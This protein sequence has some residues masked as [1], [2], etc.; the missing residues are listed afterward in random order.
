MNPYSFTSTAPYPHKVIRH[1]ETPINTSPTPWLTSLHATQRRG[2]YGN[3]SY[4]GN[5]SGYLIK[6][7]IRYFGARRIL[8]PL[9]GSGTCR[10][11]CDEL[12]VECVSFDLKEGKD[13]CSRDSYADLG[14]FDFIWTHPP[15]WRMINY[16]DDPR[17]MSNAPTLNTFIKQMGDLIDCCAS[18]L[19]PNGKIAVLM[20][21]YSEHGRYLPLTYLTMQE[22]MRRGLWPACTE[23]VRLQYRN[24]S[25]K[26]TY[27]S[28]FIPGVHDTCMVFE[29]QTENT[30][31]L[32]TGESPRNR[33]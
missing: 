26:K 18:V 2:P 6:D 13:A 32:K 22:A 10:D 4:R 11:V 19:S 1:P 21:N 28:S 12:N 14:Q 27:S 31:T 20:G 15:Y 3:A 5:C 30:E 29:V 16:G 25:S 8:D 9:T 7:L 24:T 23:I 17:C 33:Q